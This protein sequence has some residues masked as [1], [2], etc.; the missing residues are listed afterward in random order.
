MKYFLFFIT[1]LFLGLAFQLFI[2]QCIFLPGQS[3]SILLI[4]VIYLGL[5]RG[6][7][8]AQWMG[9]GWGLLWDG[10]MM[11]HLGSHSLFFT[12]VGFAAGY[13]RRHLDQTKI[14]AQSVSAGIVVFLYQ[15]F[16]SLGGHLFGTNAPS[17]PWVLF[18]L[19]PLLNALI[20]PLVVW[21]LHLWV[22]VWDLFPNE[23]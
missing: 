14:W 17:T 20:A 22:Q 21:G 16:D 7:T 10:A 19:N 11:G 15:L 1:T 6:G 5:R 13:L 8:V 23:D 9:W 2:N 12:L 18:L 3:W 4:A